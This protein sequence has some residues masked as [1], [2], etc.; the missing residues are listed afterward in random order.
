MAKLK[1]GTYVA[2]SLT[3]EGAVVAASFST[4]AGAYQIFADSAIGGA[5]ANYLPKFESNANYE[6]VKSIISDNG[7]A[8]AVAGTIT[9][10]QVFNA[11]WNDIADFVAVDDA[12]K[13]EAG[14][15]YSFD[16]TSH[17]KTESYSEKGT[18][19]IASDTYGFGVG[20]KALGNQL[21]IAIGGFVLA[22][23]KKVYP[24]GTPLTSYKEGKLIKASFFTKLLFPERIVGTF[25]RK[26]PEAIW[27]TTVIVNN[28]CWVKVI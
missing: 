2:G 10:S 13:V 6:M 27:N 28:R 21:P 26:E 15:A 17:K 4:A 11:V 1:G 23:C 12:C 5:R 8:A 3:A 18:L 22:F 16:G 7:T 20:Q 19:G 14:Y 25:Y 24:T 9:A